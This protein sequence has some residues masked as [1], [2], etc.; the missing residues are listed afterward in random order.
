MA[1]KG[2]SIFP[3]P[4]RRRSS[5]LQVWGEGPG[6]RR[7]L[8]PLPPRLCAAL[9]RTYCLAGSLMADGETAQPVADCGGSGGDKCRAQD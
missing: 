2:R 3:L 5:G 6:P 4:V 9:P 1:E 8:L 7:A